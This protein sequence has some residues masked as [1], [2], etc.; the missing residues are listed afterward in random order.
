MR[1]FNLVGNIGC[2]DLQ[3]YETKTLLN[4]MYFNGRECLVPTNK[5]KIF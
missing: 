4:I 3:V 1:P 2:N 5:E